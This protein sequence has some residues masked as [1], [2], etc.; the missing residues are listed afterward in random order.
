MKKAETFNFCC[1]HQSLALPSLWLCGRH[2]E[3]ALWYFHGSV[4]LVNAENFLIVG[5]YCFV[6]RQNVTCLRPFIRYGH[7][8]SE[9]EDI[10]IGRLTVVLNRCAKN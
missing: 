6:Y 3:H 4:C 2:F 10:I 9:V 7:Y 5:F 1:S 8:A